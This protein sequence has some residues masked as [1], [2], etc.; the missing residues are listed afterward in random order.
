MTPRRRR[1][2]PSGLYCLNPGMWCASAPSVRCCMLK[3]FF[4]NQLYL[5]LAQ[6]LVAALAAMVVVL[7]ARKRGMHLERDTLV[8]MVR[9]IV[10]IVAV[11]SILLLLLRGP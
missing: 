11:G 7:L 2:W 10:Q 8:A 5:G 1:V 4:S 3:L 6:A 9:G